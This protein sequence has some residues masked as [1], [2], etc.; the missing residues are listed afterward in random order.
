M[1]CA[2]E[3]QEPLSWDDHEEESENKMRQQRKQSSYG[4]ENQGVRHHVTSLTVRETGWRI[5]N[6]DESI[7]AWPTRPTTSIVGGWK[8]RTQYLTTRQN[9]IKDKVVQ[10]SDP[11]GSDEATDSPSMWKKTWKKKMDSKTMLKKILEK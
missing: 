7:L 4:T 1:W 3:E 11:S 6:K 5:Y 2:Y 9:I 8:V 10:G